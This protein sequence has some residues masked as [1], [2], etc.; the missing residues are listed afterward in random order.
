MREVL[1]IIAVFIG[2]GKRISV[3]FETEGKQHGLRGEVLHRV[4]Q[5]TSMHLPTTIVM[6]NL[7]SVRILFPVAERC[8]AL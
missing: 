4:P 6:L 2:S 5:Y 3:V 7:E 8:F 1:R